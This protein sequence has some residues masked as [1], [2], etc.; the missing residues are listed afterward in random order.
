[1]SLSS[2]VKQA[3]EGDEII[4]MVHFPPFNAQREN[5]LFTDLFEKYGIKKVVYGHLHGN[6]S[7]TDSIVQK[8]GVTYYLTSCDQTG[9]KLVDIT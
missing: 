8:N 1:M 7:R 4:V 6:A 9:C 2:A 3:E 5:S